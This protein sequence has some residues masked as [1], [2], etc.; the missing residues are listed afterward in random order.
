[1][2]EQPNYGNWVS[3][4]LIVIFA[5]LAVVLFILGELSIWLVL[6]ATLCAALAAYFTLARYEFASQGGNVQERV[7]DLVIQHVDWNGEGEAL[8]IGCGNGALSI[9][10]ATRFDRARV[11]GIDYW[12]KNWE[13]SKQTCERNAAIAGVGERTCFQKASASALPFADSHFDAVVSNLVFHEVKGVGDKKELVREALRV[14][15][16]GG[17][18]ALQ[19]LFFNS[20]IYGTK[21]DLL[22]AV[23]RMGATQAELIETRAEEFIPTTL[24]LPFMLGTM[25]IL[26]G[27][28]SK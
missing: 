20:R 17:T 25:G 14:L 5:V 3:L 28:K 10:L 6:P 4:R 16:P 24:K 23:H 13:F 19:D 1:M 7:W 12:G 9:K 18:F 8:D 26:V 21:E 11:V 15:K 22:D 27:K 2:N